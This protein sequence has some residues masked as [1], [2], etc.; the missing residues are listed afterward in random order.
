MEECFGE[1]VMIDLS[2]DG[3]KTLRPLRG[4]RRGPHAMPWGAIAVKEL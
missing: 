4:L 1:G 2:D 3:S